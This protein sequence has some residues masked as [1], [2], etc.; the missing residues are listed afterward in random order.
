MNG[1]LAVYDNMATNITKDTKKADSIYVERTVNPVYKTYMI[2]IDTTVL[3]FSDRIKAI[4]WD[5]TGYILLYKRLDELR[6]QWPRNENE[7]KLLTKQ[8]FRW[9]M[10]GLSI[11]PKNAFRPGKPGTVF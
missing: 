3:D 7:L 11:A 8:Q 9:L 6:F 10:E 4:Y 1:E 2:K 5:G